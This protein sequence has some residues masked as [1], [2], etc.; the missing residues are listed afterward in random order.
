MGSE[1]EGGTSLGMADRV[2]F[3][4]D[5]V[6]DLSNSNSSSVLSQIPAGGGVI[7]QLPLPLLTSSAALSNQGIDFL[8]KGLHL[9]WPPV[10]IAYG[11]D[12]LEI[13]PAV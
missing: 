12:S 1:E 3:L 7:R 6:L 13:L 10:L 5:R 2:P 8:C 4:R 11:H 9:P